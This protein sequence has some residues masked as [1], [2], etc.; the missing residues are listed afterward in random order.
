MIKRLVNKI[1]LTY[2]IFRFLNTA[3]RRWR[4]ADFNYSDITGHIITVIPCSYFV[5]MLCSLIV[6]AVKNYRF[7]QW[8]FL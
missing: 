8:N 3:R 4:T 6:S 5:L 7:S 2:D 1:F